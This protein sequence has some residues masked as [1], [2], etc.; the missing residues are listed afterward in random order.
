MMAKNETINQMQVDFEAFLQACKALTETQARHPGICG[1]WSAK[2]VVD[3]LTGWQAESV[4]IL[5]ELID[6]EE[7][8]IA[9]DIDGFNAESVKEREALDWDQSLVALEE[10]FRAFDR[11]LG[12]ISQE[13]YET[14]SGVESWVQAMIHEY[15]FHL[16][17]IEQAQK[18]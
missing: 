12:E 8:E 6:V 5:G 16:T 10:S 17:H 9:L 14:H 2:Q 4:E 1:E 15:C 18:D 11:A 13:A 3:H 7:N